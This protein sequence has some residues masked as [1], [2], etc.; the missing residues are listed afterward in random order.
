MNEN[1][2][3]FESWILAAAAAAFVLL[4][5]FFYPSIFAYRDEGN[6]LSMAYALREGAFSIPI[7]K[8]PIQAFFM[9]GERI[10]P[11]YPWGNAL[12]LVPWTFAGWHAVFLHGLIWHLAG[13]FLIFKLA[14]VF[15]INPRLAALLYLFY[16][17][18]V[19]YS[20]T[21]MSDIPSMV[22]TLAASYFYFK[23]I[24]SFTLAGIF[25]G[26]G[27][28]FRTSNLFVIL[29]FGAILLWRALRHKEFRPLASFSV[30]IL[31]CFALQFALQYLTYG[32]PFKSGYTGGMPFSAY[33]SIQYARE[34]LSH[35]LLNLLLCYPLMLILFFFSK[36][37]RRP[38]ILGLLA[39]LLGFFTV[40]YFHDAFP[41]KMLTLF[42]GNRYL[43]PV[44]P[45]LILGYAGTAEKIT[46]PLPLTLRR[47]LFTGAAIL[48]MASGFIVSR[49][50]QEALRGQLEMKEAIYTHTPPGSILI[51]DNNSAELLQYA[52]G[53][54]TYLVFP[55]FKER[56]F[57]MAKE[58]NQ[59]LY[60]IK[61]D[62]Q[63][64]DKGLIPGLSEEDQV[65]IA[66]HFEMDP[67]VQ[68]GELVILSLKPKKEMIP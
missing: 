49:G 8:I 51:Y 45:F 38:E 4:Y 28:L 14:G 29:P 63:Y 10:A 18:F 58:P 6:Y 54:R 22:L 42:F 56:F 55:E 21:L 66:Q 57:S 1:S 43:F 13:G 36:P 30:G 39:V 9:V 32:D 31:P 17:S 46:G 25:L 5:F 35:Y 48:L 60:L 15:K 7:F 11:V 16:P 53:K 24:P 52:W 50:H 34:N 59:G 40:Y 65:D 62:F 67:V 41:G 19:F 12:A 20:R 2:S 27:Y 64:A 68:A 26:I 47:F 37:V 33:F 3:K 61:R 23:A 44:I